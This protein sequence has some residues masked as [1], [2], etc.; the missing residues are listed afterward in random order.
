[1]NRRTCTKIIGFT[2]ILALGIHGFLLADVLA[3]Q[4][5]N[6]PN[7]YLCK[8]TNTPPII[9]NMVDKQAVELFTEWIRSLLK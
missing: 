8:W 4:S 5:K 1:M 9:G 2:F 3:P 6:K 7:L